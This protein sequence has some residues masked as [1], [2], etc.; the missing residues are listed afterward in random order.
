MKIYSF[1]MIMLKSDEGEGYVLR[2]KRAG[3][4]CEPVPRHI[5]DRSGAL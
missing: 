3:G 1:K 2:L 4:W 5:L